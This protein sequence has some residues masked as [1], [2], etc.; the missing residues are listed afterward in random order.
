MGLLIFGI[1]ILCL[2]ASLTSP[3]RPLRKRWRAVVL[4][5]IAVFACGPCQPD[6]LPPPPIARSEWISASGHI[7][8]G[9]K[10]Y[11]GSPPTPAYCCEVV[12]IGDAGDTAVVRVRY[13]SGDTEFKTRD[14]IKS[15]GWVRSDDPALP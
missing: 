5:P 8:T 10:I 11:F 7:L 4:I 1:L 9:V 12:D 13:P 14:A 2:F 6:E 3:I 15:W